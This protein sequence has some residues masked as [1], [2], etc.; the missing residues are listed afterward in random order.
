MQP[1]WRKTTCGEARR[2]LKRRLITAVWWRPD[3]IMN[4]ND[5]DEDVALVSGGKDDDASS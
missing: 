1:T 5:P 3:G 2:L 4:H